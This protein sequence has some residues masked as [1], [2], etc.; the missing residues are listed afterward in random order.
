MANGALS[1]DWQCHFISRFLWP[2]FEVETCIYTGDA[3]S[4]SSNLS[5]CPENE[6]KILTQFG[7]HFGTVWTFLNKHQI[8]RGN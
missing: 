7:V 5:V 2:I 3:G 4:Y 6:N 1:T 8:S